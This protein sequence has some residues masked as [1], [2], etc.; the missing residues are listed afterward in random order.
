MSLDVRVVRLI[1]IEVTFV[2]RR[3]VGVLG[4]ARADVG[5]EIAPWS[6]V[7]PEQ[8]P[9]ANND[10]SPLSSDGTLKDVTRWFHIVDIPRTYKTLHQIGVHHMH[11]C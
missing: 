10:T 3:V 1:L 7:Q 9:R 6:Q 5:G 2:D 4:R 11:A 8:V